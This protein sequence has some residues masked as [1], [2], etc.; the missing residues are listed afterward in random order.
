M[1]R[2]RITTPAGRTYSI[3]APEGATLEDAYQYVSEN[4]PDP[5]H[6]PVE[7]S[8]GQELSSL[9]RSG[10]EKGKAFFAPMIPGVEMDD[11]VAQGLG[12]EDSGE[13][14]RA[15]TAEF[16]AGQERKADAIR[17]TS[18]ATEIGKREI[19]GAEGWKESAGAIIRNP[20]VV[21]GVI[22]ESM[23]MAAPAL[24]AAAATGGTAIM[25][26]MVGLGSAATEYGGTI[27]GTLSEAGVDI[28]NPSE[29]RRAL[30]DEK[31]MERARE[32]GLKR[33]LTIGAMDALT[34]KLAGR[35]LAGAT[36]PGSA[37]VRAGGEVGLQAAGGAS[38]EALGSLAAGDKVKP[39]DVIMEAIAEIPTGAFEIPRNFRE[40]RSVFLWKDRKS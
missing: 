36:G 3:N 32:R 21:G 34:A 19:A 12:Y 22:A 40:A 27:E 16:I 11:S 38:G 10:M 30:G 8:L 5:V 25:P 4:F 28:S 23:G 37:A 14:D 26:L 2:Y 17:R 18:V 7:P 20:R 33:G 9:G 24:A 15:Q 31:L 39:S 6:K 1:P 13:A 29:V 35:L